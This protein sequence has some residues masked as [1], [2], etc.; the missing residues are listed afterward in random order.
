VF[1]FQC[2]ATMREGARFC[3]QCGADQA[4][5]AAPAAQ[6]P[7]APTGA[8]VATQVW[9]PARQAPAPPAG[10]PAWA[11]QPV[12]QEQ[13]GWNQQ[14]GWDQQRERGQQPQWGVA[15][16]GP[17][18][19]TTGSAPAYGQAVRAPAIGGRAPTL[20]PTRGSLVM[21]LGGLLVVLAPFLTWVTL[22]VAFAKINFSYRDFEDNSGLAQIL[23]IGAA[24]LLGAV[25]RLLGIINRT[26]ARVWGIAVGALGIAEA[27]YR[28]L[29]LRGDLKD[30]GLSLG[31]GDM[32]LGFWLLVL[33]AILALAGGA[34]EDDRSLVR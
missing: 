16:A 2:G 27:V 7:P 4:G 25:L 23:V 20:R 14:Q 18:P 13:Q 9:D 5:T 11:A 19:V 30:V 29:D 12:W 8:P 15:A 1:C 24:A 6:G 28:F 10:S 34:I 33:G 3:S 26:V 31:P 22:D 32:Q 17:A 21:L